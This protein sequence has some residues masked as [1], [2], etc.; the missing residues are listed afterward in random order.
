MRAVTVALAAIPVVLGGLGLAAVVG[1]FDPFIAPTPASEETQISQDTES[2]ATAASQATGTVIDGRRPHLSVIDGRV[3]LFLPAPMPAILSLLPIPAVDLAPLPGSGA[4]D[5]PAGPGEADAGSQNS[6]G[7][8]AQSGSGAAPDPNV[9]AGPASPAA[10]QPPA[11]YAPPA[12]PSARPPAPPRTPGNDDPGQIGGPRFDLDTLAS[13]AGE[14]LN[15]AIPPHAGKPGRPAHADTSGPPPHA[16]DNNRPA[17]A[18]ANGRP[19]HAAG[20]GPESDNGRS[21]PR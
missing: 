5:A 7:A 12:A 18:A 14:R 16:S 10:M 4:D 20:G 17:H 13:R 21:G 11:A 1:A 8:G 19:D 3:N 15:N 6:P 2:R 9:G